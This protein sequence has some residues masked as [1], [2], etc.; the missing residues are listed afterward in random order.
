MRSHEDLEVWKRA[1]LLADRVYDLG[2]LLP[3]DERFG[4]TS[5]IQRAAV[6]VA[7]NIAEGAARDSTKDFLRY[8]SIAQG[9]LAEVQTL[10]IIIRRR[11]FGSQEL[12]EELTEL[13]VSISKM[14][15]GLRTSLRRKLERNNDA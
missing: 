15:V 4:L 9:S 7:A 5:Q 13:S 1:I 14:L 11:S 2:K 10:L 6:S 3:S 8:L 12:T